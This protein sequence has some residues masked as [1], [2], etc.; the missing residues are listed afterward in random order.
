MLSL[1]GNLHH[2]RRDL[3][4]WL[5]V[6]QIPAIGFGVWLML[7]L[8]ERALWILELLL[9]V[10]IALG[11]LSMMLRP[12]PLARVSRPAAALGTG[13][14]GGV[15]GDLFAASGPVMG[16]F[17]YRQPISLAEIWAT[18]F[19]CFALTTSVR[20]LYVG[21]DGGLIAQVRPYAGAG[22]S[23]VALI[24]MAVRTFPPTRTRCS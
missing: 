6:G 24:T 5:S 15:V 16:W 9:G 4:G 3:F 1:R 14:C 10:F 17:N 11:S 19:S 8:Y 13:I 7:S 22:L 18:L 20:T 23:L 21:F 12:E 2:A